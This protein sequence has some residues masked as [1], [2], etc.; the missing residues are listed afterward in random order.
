MWN[1]RSTAS[2]VQQK[3]VCMTYHFVLRYVVKALLCD[4]D[5]V[6]DLVR[7]EMREGIVREDGSFLDSKVEEE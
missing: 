6:Q 5:A 4:D 2:V 1:E 7:D 3:V